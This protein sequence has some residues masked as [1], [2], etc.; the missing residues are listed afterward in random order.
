MTEEDNCKLKGTEEEFITHSCCVCQQTVSLIFTKHFE[1]LECVKPVCRKCACRDDDT[2]Q[3]TCKTCVQARYIRQRACGW[4]ARHTADKFGVSGQPKVVSGSRG[5]NGV[6]GNTAAVRDHTETVMAMLVGGEVDSVDTVVWEDAEY[7]RLHHKHHA[8][9]ALKLAEFT[10]ALREVLENAVTVSQSPSNIHMDISRIVREIEDDVRTVGPI[11]FV[12][13]AG[14]GVTADST[15]EDTLAT[16]VINKIVMEHVTRQPCAWYPPGGNR[17]ERMGRKKSDEEIDKKEEDTLSKRNPNGVKRNISSFND[18]RCITQPVFVQN[19]DSVIRRNSSSSSSSSSS[20]RSSFSSTSSDT[21]MRSSSVSSSSSEVSSNL[22]IPED[23]GVIHFGENEDDIPTCIIGSHP[24][25]DR[26]LGGGKVYDPSLGLYRAEDRYSEDNDNHEDLETVTASNWQDN[27]LF[28]QPTPVCRRNSMNAVSMLL[29]NATDDVKTQI[30]NT[31]F[32]LVSELSEEIENT[33]CNNSVNNDTDVEMNEH[34]EY[35]NNVASDYEKSNKYAICDLL[36]VRK[37]TIKISSSDP[38]LI[39]LNKYYPNHRVDSLDETNCTRSK[40]RQ[41]LNVDSDNEVSL[42]LSF[43][44]FDLKNTSVCLPRF[45]TLGEEIGESS[46]DDLWMVNDSLVLSQETNMASISECDETYFSREM[47]GK[48]LFG[49]DN[50]DEEEYDPSRH[51]ALMKTNYSDEDCEDN[52]DCYDRSVLER[53]RLYEETIHGSISTQLFP[54]SK[55]RKV[56]TEGSE[57]ASQEQPI[58]HSLLPEEE[59]STYEEE[60][61][62]S[63]PTLPSVKQLATKFQAQGGR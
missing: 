8:L 5:R 40:R 16:T 4:L 60:D 50:T 36:P 14:E 42:M 47:V 6:S 43:K 33:I 11:K 57:I 25:L 12:R 44:Q 29:P 39:K 21:S 34:L 37:N 45:I 18:F 20:T 7:M 56:W 55:W 1:C 27:W 22:T 19:T 54:A 3:W 41:N 15:Y 62:L 61:S 13:P 31:D 58:Q 52:P 17:G 28:S 49:D 30:G 38:N 9:L 24:L 35:E 10:T 53:I 59:P 2:L 51:R 46:T 32:D 48:E 23:K 26:Y 63:I